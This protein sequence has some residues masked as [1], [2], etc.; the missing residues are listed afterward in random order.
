MKP[1][2]PR[3]SSSATISSKSEWIL[4]QL[5]DKN[6]VSIWKRKGLCLVC[7]G[8]RENKRFGLCTACYESAK[9]D[10]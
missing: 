2:T 4:K 3:P 8:E 9:T 1:S 10:P 7:G 5:R 6:R